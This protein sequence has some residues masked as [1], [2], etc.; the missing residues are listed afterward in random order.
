MKNNYK[1]NLL[2]FF[3]VLIV[4]SGGF[5]AGTIY[6]KTG[7]LGS[8]FISKALKMQKVSEI[9]E[10][11]FYFRDKINDNKAFDNS[12][13]GFVSNLGDPFS[14]YLNEEDLKAFTE[15]VD[16]NYVGIGVEIAVDENNL[17]SVINSFEGSPARN[18]GIKTA[19]KIIKVNGETV[20]G[21]MLYEVVS[22]IKGKLGETVDI[23][24]LSTDGQTKNLKIVRSKVNVE[25]VHFKKIGDDIGYIKITSFDVDSDKEFLSKVSNFNFDTIKGVIIDLRSNSGGALNSTVKIA[26]YIMPK[27]NIVKIKYTNGKEESFE[28]DENAIDVP[29]VVLINQGSASAAELLAGGLKD[30]N[31]AILLGQKSFG[32][33]VVGQTFSVDSKSALILTIGEYFLPSGINIH[34]KGLQP[35]ILVELNNKNKSNSL[36]SE[37]EDNQLQKAL[38][39]LRK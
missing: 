23:D 35:D 29:I 12:L 27:A 38:E 31:K 17:I 20:T 4:A 24:I 2:Y 3:I 16:G 28:S 39:I 25:T 13:K 36:L 7:S 8:N 33:G 9:I 26:D 1:K 21:D 15:S 19:D 22:K 32:K 10:E 6:E 34:K 37:N 30:N 18:A 5:F 11:N 14:S